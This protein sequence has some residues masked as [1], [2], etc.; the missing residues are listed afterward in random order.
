MDPSIKV[1]ENLSLQAGR[2]LLD[3]FRSV[4][5]VAHK[6][7]IDLVTEVDQQSE[8]SLIKEIRRR[9]PDHK[10][11]TEERGEIQGSSSKVWLIDPLDGTVNYAYGIPIFS[12]SIAY[13]EDREVVLGAVYDPIQDELFTAERGA[14]SKL[15]GSSIHVSDERS[16]DQSL[17]ATGFSYDV[18][19]AHD[20]NLDNYSDFALRSLGV[21][22]LGSAAID[23]VYVAVGRFDGF[24]EVSIHPWDIAAGGLIV[25][26]AGGMVTNVRGGERYLSKHPSILA[27]NSHIHSQMLTVL[28]RNHKSKFGS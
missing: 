12:V 23:L 10:I 11:I 15:N 19:S 1:L 5:Q 21:R 22:R 25:E 27:T 18:R 9:Y 24:W 28:E 7:V 17:L 3:R 16:L 26:E 4:I 6:G 2:I 8:D 14:G 13:M 20:N